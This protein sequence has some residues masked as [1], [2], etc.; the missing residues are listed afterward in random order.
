[1]KT[2]ELVKQLQL[3]DPTGEAE[4]C[5]GNTDI[6]FVDAEGAFYDG[7]LQV[8]R[9]NPDSQYYNIVG[10]DYVGSGIKVVI[11]TLSITDAI[12]NDSEIP[13]GYIGISPTTRKYYEDRVE[14]RRQE[15][16]D[17]EREIELEHFIRYLTKRLGAHW[18]DD[19]DDETIRQSA[20]EFF[21]ANMHRKDPMPQEINEAA[22]SIKEEGW[23]QI[24]SWNERREMQW[25]KEI[26]IVIEDNTIKLTRNRLPVNIE[27]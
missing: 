10:A 3:A 2:H 26:Q 23:K 13:V 20:T 4:C 22:T 1:M 24:L 17:M 18:S 15:V 16:R 27:V 5:V 11:H 25:D 14:A 8:L 19:F 21:D 7:C 6:H 12:L 9:R